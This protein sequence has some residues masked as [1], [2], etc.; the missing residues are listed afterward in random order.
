MKVHIATGLVLITLFSVLAVSAQVKEITKDEYYSPW[1]AAIQKARGL[2][3]R[4]ISK[5]E[6]Y[7]NGKISATDEWLYEYVLPDK[8]RYVHLEKRDGKSYR[9][10]QVDIDKLKYCKQDDKPWELVEGPCIGGGAGGVPNAQSIKYTVE[11]VRSGNNDAKLFTQYITF[12]DPFTKE[13]NI[14]LSFYESKYWLGSDGFIIRE[15]RKY[16]L[17]ETKRIDR[18]TVD[19]YEYNPKDLMIE[20]PIK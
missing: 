4:K 12:K 11:T 13:S 5:T 15:E 17:A 19:T 18:L 1:R 9:T 10:E 14:G 8:I 20:A 7:K 2:N 3:R 6:I 16:G